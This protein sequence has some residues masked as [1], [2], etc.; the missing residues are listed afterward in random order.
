M[1][2][3][4]NQHFNSDENKF[5]STCGEIIDRKIESNNIKSE[6]EIP[7]EDQKEKKKN[8]TFKIL[9]I[10]LIVLLGVSIFVYLRIQSV[11]R[12][13]EESVATACEE[14]S[15]FTSQDLTSSLYEHNT[16]GNLLVM[17]ANLQYAAQY[18]ASERSTAINGIRKIVDEINSL[19]AKYDIQRDLDDVIGSNEAEYIYEELV[20]AA[21]IVETW[22]SGQ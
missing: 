5:C 2:F 7:E 10:L 1:A 19:A 4:K 12:G 8:S 18:G 22:C 15:R 17:S 16:F 3:C 6:L 13:A 20:G 14:W 9:I 11:E 21:F